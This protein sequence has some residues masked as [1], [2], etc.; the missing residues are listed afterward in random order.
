MLWKGR[1][2]IKG[3]ENVLEGG[4]QFQIRRTEKHVSRESMVVRKVSICT[5][6]RGT[7]VLGRGYSLCKSPGNMQ[8]DNMARRE[9]VGGEEEFREGTEVQI[10][11][12]Q[13]GH[14]KRGSFAR[15]DRVGGC[16]EDLILGIT[17]FALRSTLAA[18]LSLSGRALKVEAERSAERL[19]CNSEK[20]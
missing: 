17:C 9:S 19:F 8:K 5:S 2:K 16:V 20:R 18:V 15:S 11:E 1:S 3:T 13:E 12:V 6:E 7:D 10:L 4:L 14:S